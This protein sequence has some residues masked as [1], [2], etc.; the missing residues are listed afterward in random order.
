MKLN[1]C[2]WCLHTFEKS[3]KSAGGMFEHSA[4]ESSGSTRKLKW[5]AYCNT[6]CGGKN[7]LVAPFI[8]IAS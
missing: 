1:E 3:I 8:F 5:Q 2:Q 7:T 4:N 6:Y